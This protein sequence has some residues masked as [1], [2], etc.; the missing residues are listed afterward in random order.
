MGTSRGVFE[1]RGGA[2]VTLAV[3]C[4]VET[5]LLLIACVCEGV[6][7]D[8]N[9]IV[10]WWWW[11]RESAVSRSSW[12]GTGFFGGQKRLIETAGRVQE[13]IKRDHWSILFAEPGR[14]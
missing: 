12:G 9:K 3:F 6:V 14:R 7:D 5:L 10:W 1:G 2:V 8:F 11:W 4:P 13:N